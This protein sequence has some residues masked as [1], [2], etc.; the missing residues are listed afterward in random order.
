M[1]VLIKKQLLL[2]GNSL[3]NQVRAYYLTQA[4]GP[5]EMY[6]SNLCIEKVSI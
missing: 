6:L 2:P 3:K 1:G 4:T 5:Q